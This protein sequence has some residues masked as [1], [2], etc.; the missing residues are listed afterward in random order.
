MVPI[1]DSFISF[2][3]L[4]VY[5]YP[6][7]AT[8]SIRCR[9]YDQGDYI[10]W[11]IQW[12]FHIKSISC[13]LW[14]NICSNCRWW[15]NSAIQ[16]LPYISRCQIVVKEEYEMLHFDTECT[17]SILQRGESCPRQEMCDPCSCTFAAA[18]PALR[19]AMEVHVVRSSDAPEAKAQCQQTR[20]TTTSQW[21]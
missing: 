8:T 21:E 2:C 3:R 15:N 18:C 7:P 6:T 19:S 12:V 11:T 1:Y 9:L 10:L 14:F 16:M 4:P 13:W 5:T 20:S 17:E